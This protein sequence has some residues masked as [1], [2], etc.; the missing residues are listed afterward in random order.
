[1]TKLLIFNIILFQISATMLGITILYFKNG[2][3]ELELKKENEKLERALDKQKQSSN[4]FY[5]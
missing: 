3:K 2:K 5:D 4:G 1:M